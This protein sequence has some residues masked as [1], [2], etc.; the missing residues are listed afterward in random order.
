MTPDFITQ[1]SR[2]RAAILKRYGTTTVEAQNYG[3]LLDL[4]EIVWRRME[5]LEAIV[6]KGADR[7]EPV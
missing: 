6:V 7:D 5:R 2:V 3:M 4:V 1:L